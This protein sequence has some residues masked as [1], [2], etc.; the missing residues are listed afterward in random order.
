M[1]SFI[2]LFILQ[3]LLELPWVSAPELATRATDM[4]ECNSPLT[5]RRGKRAV[6]AECGQCHNIRMVGDDA[7][8]CNEEE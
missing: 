8:G 5:I 3:M 1:N 4:A 7:S 2:Y 6:P